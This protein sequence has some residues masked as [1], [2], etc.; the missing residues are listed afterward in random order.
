MR[1]YRGG[2][3]GLVKLYYKLDK[4]GFGW[5]TRYSYHTHYDLRAA[6]SKLECVP[7]I[8]N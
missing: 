5:V 6:V 2:L 7:G 4:F 1:A 3:V 8:D